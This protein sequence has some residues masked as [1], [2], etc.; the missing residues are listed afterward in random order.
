MTN[1]ERNVIL[2]IIDS[3]NNNASETTF[4]SILEL[5]I[6]YTLDS[7][8]SHSFL[9]DRK[10]YSFLKKYFGQG[11]LS[12][13]TADFSEH[14]NGLVGGAFDVFSCISDLV[15]VAHAI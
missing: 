3:V 11:S 4:E 9:D 10:A 1:E 12:E 6:K 2:R 8:I 15:P 5:A 14:I 13:S 7:K